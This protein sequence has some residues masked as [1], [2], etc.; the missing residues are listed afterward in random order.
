MHKNLGRLYGLIRVLLAIILIILITIML[1]L[2]LYYET[3]PPYPE[4][5][6]PIYAIE[7]FNWQTG[8]V[9]VQNI[10]IIIVG[11]ALI[12]LGWKQMH[13]LNVKQLDPK[14][15]A[16]EKRLATK[17]HNIKTRVIK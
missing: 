3:N 1:P 8:S 9:I 7:W 6:Q 17:L 2:D 10:W 5:L 11:S 12:F 13:P 16:E 15:I 4:F 14:K